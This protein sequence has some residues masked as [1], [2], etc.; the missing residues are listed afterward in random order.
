MSRETRYDIAA[1]AAVT[2]GSL[3]PYL[4]LLSLNQI[5]ITD[6][7]FTSDIFNGELPARALAGQLVAAGQVPVWSSQL[8]SGM[9][10]AASS[11]SEP[12]SLGLFTALPPAPA[13]CILVVFY[14][15]IAAHG[16]YA[17][18]L[19]L[20]AT[21]TG[22]CL[23]GIT[24][25]GSGYL[26]TQL[27][28][29]GIISTVVWLPLALLML[30][31]ALACN[32]APRLDATAAQTP[33]SSP[34]T[35]T[36]SRVRDI[37]LFGVIYAEQVLGGFPQS[38]YI[39][40]L[41]YATWSL[42]LL[43]GLRA[44]DSPW[45]L[46]LRLAGALGLA[47]TLAVSTGAVMLLPLNELGELSDRSGTQSWQFASMLPYSWSDALNFV[48]PYANGNVA[49]GTY[50]AP[51][52]FWENYGYV[53]A[54]TFALALFGLFRGIRRPRVLLLFALGVGAFSMV[55]G[56]NTPL[57]YLAWRYLPGMGHFRFPTRF[58]FVV[59]LAL[60]LLAAIGLS[61]LRPLLERMLVRVAPRVVGL[62]P[63]V[64]VL[65][66]ALDLFVN[67]F[68]QNPFVPAREWLSKP[69]T[70]VALGDSLTEARLFTPH[71]RFFHRL[72]FKAARG[73]SDLNPYRALRETVAPNIGVFWGAAT[74]DCYM[75]IAPVW[76]VDV[77]GDHSRGGFVVPKT[78]QIG[79]NAIVAG[80]SFASVLAGLGVTHLL[81]PVPVRGLAVQE[82][83]YAGPIHLYRLPGKRARVVPL[84][85]MVQSNHEAAAILTQASFDPSSTVLLHAPAADPA[86]TPIEGAVPGDARV[87]EEDSRHLRVQVEAAQGGYLLLA[88]TFYPGW[89]ASVDG[90]EQTLY[91]ANV[92]LRAVRLARGS[93]VVDFH[94]DAK[95]FFR[96]LH[97][98][99]ASAS[100]LLAWLVVAGSVVRRRRAGVIKSSAPIGA[101]FT[102]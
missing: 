33:T 24:Y 46:R 79:Q 32:R 30:D 39:C 22:A 62:L 100:L 49:D 84:A 56:P 82:I 57:Y 60:C 47:V 91:R 54:A 68:H 43:L 3:L 42:A 66:T 13:L 86:L 17:L 102:T 40:G 71:H 25:A 98:S 93:R 18:A 52:F 12:I 67:Q 76:Y 51:G 58:L 97:I 4:P 85:R 99:L 8:C 6:D 11:V 96:G 90:V 50:H 2:L 53:G 41:V 70:L 7:W 16:A 26:V 37:G 28:H 61:L 69:A 14:V 19:R 34:S 44:M 38:A 63:P 59:D 48:V 27:K 83:P 75:G 1:R 87:L 92:A 10:L 95:P 89:H 55:L 88:D 35:C 74:A 64:L 15:L 23:A 80:E 20:G 94:Y 36:W 81:S 29:L 77:W 31:R 9:P 21:R 73:W 45:W 101:S 5:Y 65:G 72:A 78:M